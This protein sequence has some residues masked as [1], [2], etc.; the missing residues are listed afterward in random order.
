MGTVGWID[1]AKDKDKWW[2]VVNDIINMEF[3]LHPENFVTSLGTISLSR[4]QFHS[5]ALLVSCPPV[6]LTFAE[7]VLNFPITPESIFLYIATKM[8]VIS[9]KGSC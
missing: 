9:A 1:L 2:T 7:R 8:D 6:R 3:S 4:T 5:V